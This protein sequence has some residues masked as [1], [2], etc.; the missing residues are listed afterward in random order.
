[1]IKGS[2]PTE[3]TMPCTFKHNQSSCVRL[4][5]CT[6]SLASIRGAN[7]GSPAHDGPQIKT[8]FKFGAE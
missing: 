5:T 7:D 6:R 4:L 8:E 1:M 2:S 3:S